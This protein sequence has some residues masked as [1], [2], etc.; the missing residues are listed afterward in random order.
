MSRAP[1]NTVHSSSFFIENILGRN[2]NSD[3]RSSMDLSTLK[4]SNDSVFTPVRPLFQ[5]EHNNGNSSTNS[6][7]TS[8]SPPQPEKPYQMPR[9]GL[10]WPPFSASVF[11]NLPYSLNPARLME[12]LRSGPFGGSIKSPQT[13]ST[14]NENDGDYESIDYD[15]GVVS[16]S[17]SIHTPEIRLE[18]IPSHGHRKRARVSFTTYQIRVLEERFERQNYLSSAER[19]E[20][21]QKLGLT[22]TQVKIWFQN[23]RYKTK[24][25]ALHEYVVNSPTNT[26]SRLPQY[27]PST[28]SHSRLLHT[29]RGGL[30]L[31]FHTPQFLH[32]SIPFEEQL[33]QVIR[34]TSG[35]TIG[36]NNLVVPEGVNFLVRQ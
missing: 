20:L 28:H 32:S 12:Y 8:L 31:T 14:P 3:K 16:S 1:Y 2:D 4:S 35:Y 23:R 10:P 5:K 22:E 6:E 15:E 7:S 9:H 36:D 17:G 13:S 18:G 24:K 29:Q 33:A 21:S 11:E 19:A 34:E 25:R 30:P 27:S 26:G